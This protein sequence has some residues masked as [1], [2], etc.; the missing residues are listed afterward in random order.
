MLMLDKRYNKS[1]RGETQKDND[2]GLQY[3]E[4]LTK[5][6]ETANK[7]MKEHF[8]DTQPPANPHSLWLHA[9]RVGKAF[10]CQP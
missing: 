1:C 8:A 5:F 4:P 10:R 7:L 3:D 9:G 2:G 6:V